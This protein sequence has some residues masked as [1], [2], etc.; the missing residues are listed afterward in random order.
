[1]QVQAAV[2]YANNVYYDV[3]NN[4]DASQ[5]AT[6]FG[7]QLA[8]ANRYEAQTLLGQHRHWRM[9]LIGPL[10][11]GPVT[12]L[13]SDTASVTVTKQERALEYTDAGAQ[14]ADKSGTVTLVDTLQRVDG[15]WLVVAVN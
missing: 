13:G 8:Q 3:M 5:V 6:A 11:Y 7:Q 15:R 10:R 9:S 2:A 12:R 1:L 4:R 14:V